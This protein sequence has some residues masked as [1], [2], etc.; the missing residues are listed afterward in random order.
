MKCQ[1]INET[2]DDSLK[3]Y[4]PEIRKYFKKTL[5]HLKITDN[6]KISLILV[7]QNRIQDIN[8]NYRFKDRVTDVISFAC[9]EWEDGEQDYLGDIFICIE[10]IYEQAKLYEHS[11]KRE[12]CFLF[13]HGLLHC[14]GYDHMNKEQESVMFTLQDEILGELK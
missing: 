1:I 13:V 12:F 8:K 14:L 3:Q 10:K 11:L 9:Q 2:N 6:K 7:N 4:Y 5:K